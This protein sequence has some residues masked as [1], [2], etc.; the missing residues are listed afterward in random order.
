[1]RIEKINNLDQGGTPE[2]KKL[3][4]ILKKLELIAQRVGSDFG[5]K[6]EIG[7]AGGGSFFNP[8]DNS[9]VFDPEHILNDE[10]SAKFTAAHEGAHRA[11]SK[12]PQEMGLALE[13]MRELYSKVGFGFI[14]NAIEDPAVNNWFQKKLPGLKDCVKKN[15]DEQFKED[16]SVL[17]TPEI[18]QIAERLGYW[19]KF[20]SF[21]SEIIRN[22]HTGSFS[23]NLDEEV[24]S[25]LE[26]TE[27]NFKESINTIPSGKPQGQEIIETARQRFKINT[28]KVWPEVEKLI[29]KDINTENLRERAQSVKR[30]LENLE[31]IESEINQ[32]SE[33]QQLSDA[34]L[35]DLQ[36][37]A[38]SIR[39]KLKE[40]GFS[41]EVLDEIQD[42]IREA[43]EKVKD[44]GQEKYGQP[45]P[46]DKFS[47]QAKKE[48]QDSFD[49]LDPETKKEIQEKSR[50]TLE[51]FEDE[52]NE[53]MES[54]L[55]EKKNDS[56]RKRREEQEINQTQD[57]ESQKER[58]EKQRQREKI[59]EKLNSMIQEDMSAYEK[60]RAE[61]VSLINDLYMRLKKILKFEEEAGR[62][63][64][65]PSGFQPD[66]E[67][68]MQSEIDS[69]Q[70]MKMWL[71]EQDPQ[72]KDYRFWSLID[73]S[74]SM[75]GAPIKEV[76]KGFAIVSEAIDKVEDFN[77]NEVKIHQGIS[78]FSDQVISYKGFNERITKRVEKKLSE[79]LLDGQGGTGT[80][81]AT[82]DA[83]EEIL[84]NAGESGNFLL[85][86]TDGQP[87]N[88][89]ELENL[90]KKTRIKRQEKNIRIGIILLVDEDDESNEEVLKTMK[91]EYGYDFGL[92]MS[93]SDS[94]EKQK[95]NFTKA[96]ADL[97][98]D[99]I[100][101]P[102]QY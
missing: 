37:N 96:L 74:G 46:V 49:Q 86:F 102:E 101:N 3:N 80:T 2:E 67:R 63:S 39:D 28:E 89:Q 98:E 36:E 79:M 83:L 14:Q 35:K 76:Y 59:K 85:T 51:D 72:K 19:P 48:L 12:H 58:Q 88:P 13:K 100:N 92:I 84:K 25:A 99:I 20:A 90:I 4:K 66:M 26:K 11:I 94:E 82:K 27:A 10:D 45:V 22:W 68:V 60:I 71:R 77:S 23:S 16:G 61:N 78:G 33:G 52:L 64:G 56:H 43:E 57:S 17:S 38:Q 50:R 32:S 41:Q 6:V 15:Y 42:K 7:K 73:L 47:D 18:Q 44:G 65:Y 34:E 93:V 1:M 30:D 91:S 29:E 5:M 69:G 8:K 24:R 97:L 70:K 21:G 75:Q 9:I 62:E 95:Q 81:E 55:K 54:K 87:D 53:K 31:K 40:E